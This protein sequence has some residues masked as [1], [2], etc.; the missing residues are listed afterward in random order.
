M[1][2]IEKII[3]FLKFKKYT[4]TTENGLIFL[5]NN[6]EYVLDKT[7][8]SYFFKACIA[9]VGEGRIFS[10]IS[11]NKNYDELVNE[12]KSRLESEENGKKTQ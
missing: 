12:I 3:N 7:G 2:E 10:V 5:Y 9:K 6:K 4:L 1:E 8:A 11:K